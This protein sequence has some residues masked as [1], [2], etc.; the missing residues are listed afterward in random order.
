M[1]YTII[2]TTYLQVL[3]GKKFH[4]GAQ[5]NHK[6]LYFEHKVREYKDIMFNFRHVRKI[7]KSDYYVLISVHA[8]IRMEQSDSHWTNFHEICI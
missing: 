3:V 7:L 5:V 4:H 2:F 6:I 8:S 1:L